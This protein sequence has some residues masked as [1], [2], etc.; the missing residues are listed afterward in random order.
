M[1]CEPVRAWSV[2]HRSSSASGS[3]WATTTCG[4]A[5]G[6]ATLEG[7]R[8]ASRSRPSTSSPVQP[9][10]SNRP[11]SRPASRARPTR[12]RSRRR[13]G[14]PGRPARRTGSPR[15]CCPR[16]ARRRRRGRRP[17]AG[18]RPWM[19]QAERRARRPAPRPWPSDPDEISTP[20]T[21]VRSGWPPSGESKREPGVQLGRVEEAL[22]GE[23][24]VVGHRAVALG[25]QEAVAVRVVDAVRRHVE[26]PVVQRPEDVERAEGGGVV[27]LVPAHPGDQRRAGRRIR[28]MSARLQDKVHLKSSMECDG[29]CIDGGPGHPLPPMLTIGQLA[30][31]QRRGARRRCAST[32]R[33]GLIHAERTAG[34]QRRYPRVELRRVA[35][36]RAAQHVGL[37]LEEIREALGRPAR[38]ADADE[39][40]LGRGSRAAGGPGWTSRSRRWR[41]CATG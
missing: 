34:N 23:H 39:G 3:T 15:C 28:V 14:C 18:V 36:V 2:A 22:G 1:R 33:E 35:F 19:P 6:G 16:P 20:G 10:T 27:L 41:R 17:A 4:P 21:S 25:E 12:C 32:S 13:S 40:G 7:L 26:H 5:V 29:R 8:S 11:R 37:S 9:S 24:G 30:D 31:A 38:R